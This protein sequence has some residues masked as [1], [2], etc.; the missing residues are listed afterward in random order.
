M[1]ADAIAQRIT[2]RIAEIEA[3]IVGLRKALDALGDGAVP[4]SPAPTRTRRVVGGPRPHALAAAQTPPGRRRGRRTV[5]A[6]AGARRTR[7]VSETTETEALEPAAAAPRGPDVPQPDV[8]PT[9]TGV[10]QWAAALRRSRRT[11]RVETTAEGVLNQL[12]SASYTASELA[13]LLNAT[14]KSVN[15]WLRVLE[16]AGAIV[17]EGALWRLAQT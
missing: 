17:R 8:E 1:D 13:K 14:S 5:H 11:R 15:D 4:A 12:S 6:D 2:V 3:D 10:E 7:S 16:T 9:A